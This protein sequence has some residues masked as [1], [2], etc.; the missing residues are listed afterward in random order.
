M[1]S[2]DF[3]DIGVITV[4]LYFG[5]IWLKQRASRSLVVGIGLITLL[6]ICAQQL[7]MYLTSWLFRA[8][9]TAVL[10][11]LVI[12]FQTD[13]RR[14]IERFVI[15][16]A[17]RKNHWSI[18]S[19]QTTDTLIEAVRKLAENKTGA[20][21]VLKGKEPLDRHIRGGVSLNG[22]ISFPLVYGLFNTGSPTHDGAVIIEGEL[23][24]KF[25]VY[26]PLS[27]NVKEGSEAGTRHAAGVGLSEV[28]DA[29]VIIVSEERGTISVAEH[30]TLEVLSSAAMLTDRINKFYR[31]VQP[32][33]KSIRRYSWLRRN[34][35]QKILSLALT[36]LLWIFFAYRAETIH[37]IFIVPI[38]WRNLPANYTIDSPRPLEA[39]VSL[40]GTE[41]NFNFDPNAL[42][43]SLDLG[44]IHDGAQDI[45]ISEGN[46]INK[47]SGV[48][49]GQIEPR[50]IRLKAYAMVAMDLPV[51]V[52]ME[53]SL[54]KNI[55]ITAMNVEP[56]KLKIMVPQFRRDE[57]SVLHTE[58][59]NLDEINQNTVLRAKVVVPDQ[60]R[61]AENAQAAVK[62]KI[63]VKESEK[64][65]K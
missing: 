25:G 19:S 16:S 7:D 22:R 31:Y 65:D 28:S 24:D 1:R 45:S 54:P 33:R 15:W 62:V 12:V 17:F 63:E 59:I 23:I 26:L 51:K 57:F 58:P 11:A 3:L 48:T 53:K 32:R 50:T 60:A 6:Y 36:L 37:R 34:F 4:L 49:V 10:L 27:Q 21:L 47:P 14:A 43:I 18:A 41:R 9:F 30:G 56:E 52:R 20:L 8:G 38:E 55:T 42:A 64:K 40:T 46:L 35:G 39:R 44:S 61:L 5:L 29:F 2:V 13:I